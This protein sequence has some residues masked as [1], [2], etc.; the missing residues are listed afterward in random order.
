MVWVQILDKRLL[1]ILVIS[2]VIISTQEYPPSG[3][4]AASKPDEN[5]IKSLGIDLITQFLTG[6]FVKRKIQLFFD[7]IDLKSRLV[8]ALSSF[9]TKENLIA[10]KRLI[11][12]ICRFANFL[13]QFLP[14]ITENDNPQTALFGLIV[15]L[16]NGFATT[17]PVTQTFPVSY[18]PP[19][20]Y[21]VPLETE[22]NKY[23]SKPLTSNENNSPNIERSPDPKTKHE[24][25][26]VSEIRIG[27]S[28]ED[29]MKVMKMIADI[30]R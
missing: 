14:D 6:D 3:V 26:G 24:T 18:G 9:C 13:N 10:L 23:S 4:P 25:V 15:N 21:T 1:F 8:Y 12:W 7:L 28:S 2:V 11:D 27:D 17:N 30:R 22:G 29:D 19:V 16:F 5:A 20:L